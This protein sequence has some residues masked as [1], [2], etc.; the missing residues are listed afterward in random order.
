LSIRL[1]IVLSHPV[2]YYSPWFCHLAARPELRVKVFYLWDFGV[3][4]ARDR[5]FGT[6]FKWDIPLLDGY[7]FKF[8]PNRSK[9]P[10]THHFR[11]L[12][13]P[14][15]PTAVA[16]WK[17]DAVLLFG[18]AYA[19][20][21]RLIFSRRLAKT[22]FYFRGDSHELC[23]SS[24]WKSKFS[25]G[26]RAL[27]FRRFAGFFAVGEANAGYFRACGVAQS[28]IHRVPHCVDNA[29]FQ[30]TAAQAEIEAIEWRRELGIPADTTVVLFAGK[31]E[32]KKRPLDLL[33]AFSALMAVA[34]GTGAACSTYLLNG[35]QEATATI[36]RE[37]QSEEQIGE[38]SLPQPAPRLIPHADAPHRHP[39]LLFV[40]SGPLEAE[41][42]KRAGADLG[43]SVFFAP[44]QN[45]TSMPMAYA[46]GDLLVLPSHGRGETW[47]LA[48]NEA[49]NMGRPA[50]VSS[51]V[52]CG[53]DLILPGKTGWIFK[54]GDQ[55]ELK[56]VLAEALSDLVRLKA[57]GQQARDHIAKY[58]YER[59]TDSLIAVIKEIR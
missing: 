4:E 11:G 21:L 33:E 13:N 45:Q 3:K 28:K 5:T 32:E 36:A 9:D 1:A 47:G 24:G 42:R 12:E 46:S 29:R 15:A 31:F 2:Q 8:I 18:Y 10:G 50:I 16:D 41:L 30:E 7:D 59:A 53:P 51:H 19:T 27:L 26:V 57:M 44:F 22:P 43:R 52:G 6:T 14:G 25:R 49:M 37:E 38:A 35:A 54:A 56:S 40:G 23:P 20:H 34:G 39:V 48:V 17:P 58:S 55:D